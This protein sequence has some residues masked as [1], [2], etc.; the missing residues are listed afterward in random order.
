MSDCR[1]CY[2]FTNSRRCHCDDPQNIKIN[3]Q[4]KT[5]EDK[6]YNSKLSIETLQ[7]NIK[8]FKKELAKLKKRKK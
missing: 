4:R 3:E 8:F 6:I 2:Y 7:E 5:L 1:Y